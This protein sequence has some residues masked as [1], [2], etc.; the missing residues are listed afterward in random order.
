[1][2]S[3]SGGG[4]PSGSDRRGGDNDNRSAGRSSRSESS[5]AGMIGSERTQNAAGKDSL[6]QAMNAARGNRPGEPE[7]GD[8]IGLGVGLGIL[9]YGAHK[10]LTD[11]PSLS[12]LMSGKAEPDPAEEAKAPVRRSRRHAES[13]RFGDGRRA[14]IASSSSFLQTKAP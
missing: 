2:G 4:G 3:P 6:D 9:G 13:W 1:M 8:V 5:R 14:P 10:A 7:M 12:P 11:P